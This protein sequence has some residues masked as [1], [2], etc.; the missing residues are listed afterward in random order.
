MARAAKIP[1]STLPKPSPITP[2]H[3]STGYLSEVREVVEIHGLEIQ[4][5]GRLRSIAPTYVNSVLELAFDIVRIPG[6]SDE[7]GPISL[8]LH[9]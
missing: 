2:V 1:P 4:P 9:E 5:R 8:S 6:I 3:N 7:R